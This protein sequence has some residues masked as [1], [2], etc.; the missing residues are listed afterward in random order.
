MAEVTYD[1]VVRLAEQ[2]MPQEQQALIAH[3]QTISKQRE[4]SFEVW[5]TLFDSLKDDSLII[6]DISP[7]R[8][9]WYDDEG[10]TRQVTVRGSFE[11]VP[12]IEP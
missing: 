11:D 6:S 7:R 4:L 3:L 10:E 9:D 12:Y 8:V 1:Q 2:L 5:K